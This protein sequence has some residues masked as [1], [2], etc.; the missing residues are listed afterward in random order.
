MLSG[1]TDLHRQLERRMAAFLGYEE[2]MKFVKAPN[3]SILEPGGEGQTPFGAAFNNTVLT[4]GTVAALARTRSER[5]EHNDAESLDAAL[6]RYKKTSP[7]YRRRHLFDG[8]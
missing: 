2:A 6:T 1:M 8:W 5:F 4:S 7:C 3:M